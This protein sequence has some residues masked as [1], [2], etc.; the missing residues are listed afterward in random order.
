MD[1]TIIQEE[2]IYNEQTIPYKVIGFINI[3]SVEKEF[4]SLQSA[5]DYKQQMFRDCKSL[6]GEPD[7]YCNLDIVQDIGGLRQR[8]DNL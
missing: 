6:H 7:F 2:Q 1:L 5:I 3:S 8:V 4:D